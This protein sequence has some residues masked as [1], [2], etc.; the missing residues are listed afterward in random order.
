MQKICLMRFGLLVVLQRL[1]CGTRGHVLLGQKKRGSNIRLYNNKAPWVPASRL[2]CWGYW[3]IEVWLIDWL[4]CDATVS[5]NKHVQNISGWGSI[6]EES[7]AANKAH[8][9]ILNFSVCIESDH[10]K[11]FSTLLFYSDSY[12]YSLSINQTPIA[13][14]S[15]AKPGSVARQPNQFNSKIEETFP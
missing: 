15:L 14:I 3:C 6:W 1:L 12:C 13:P 7:S 4:I 10:G 8:S 9:W 5:L 11:R 2:L